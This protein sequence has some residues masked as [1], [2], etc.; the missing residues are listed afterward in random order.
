[1]FSMVNEFNVYLFSTLLYLY[2]SRLTETEASFRFTE[3]DEL[4]H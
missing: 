2:T 4:K 1:M 3:Y